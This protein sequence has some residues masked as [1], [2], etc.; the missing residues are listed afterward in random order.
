MQM[1][2]KIG[3]KNSTIGKYWQKTTKV[4][5]SMQKDATVLQL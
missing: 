3:T 4:C 2:E 1:L 5:K